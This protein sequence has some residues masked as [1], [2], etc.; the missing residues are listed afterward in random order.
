VLKPVESPLE[1]L[2][3]Y[4]KGKPAHRKRSVK[5]TKSL[6]EQRR[7]L[8]VLELTEYCESLIE[9]GFRN[10]YE[11][12]KEELMLKYREESG[13]NYVKPKVED[14][15]KAKEEKAN[16]ANN[17]TEEQGKW[18]FKWLGDDQVHGPYGLNEMV[19][20]KDNYF[21]SK[22]EVRRV[23]EEEFIHIDKVTF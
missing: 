9:K 17:P 12:E 10:V 19:Y 23:G 6:E 20:W 13:K 22:V 18:Q 21:G 2:Q 4:N 1:A 11:L 16:E 14:D 5:I 7:E 15:S 8:Q 3:R